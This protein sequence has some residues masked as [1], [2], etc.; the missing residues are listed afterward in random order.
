MERDFT[1]TGKKTH[2]TLFLSRVV[3][4]ALDGEEPPPLKAQAQD[5]GLEYKEAANQILTAK[6]AFARILEKEVRS[7]V[8]SDSDVE[9]ERMDI[10]GVL[11]M[12]G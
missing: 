5:L 9:A 10:Q 11:R 4:P 7:Y 3:S 6:R 8:L 1:D 2:L 12:D